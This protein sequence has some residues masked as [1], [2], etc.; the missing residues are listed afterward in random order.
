MGSGAIIA[1][2]PSIPVALPDITTIGEY[3]NPQVVSEYINAESINVC[4]S[5][6][7]SALAV[8]LMHFL[9]QSALEYASYWSSLALSSSSSLMSTVYAQ[10]QSVLQRTPSLTISDQA[11]QTED[12][13]KSRSKGER[14]KERPCRVVDDSEEEEEEITVDDDEQGWDDRPTSKGK[15][16]IKE[17][18]RPKRTQ[19]RDREN[20][21][22][23]RVRIFGGGLPI[24]DDEEDDEESIL[25]RQVREEREK[26]ELERRRRAKAQR[27]KE[28]RRKRVE[29][30]EEQQKPRNRSKRESSSHTNNK[31]KT[32]H[33]TA[34][35]EP[36]HSNRRPRQSGKAENSDDDFEIVWE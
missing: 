26:E 36:P 24:Y 34:R 19:L 7:S 29:E 23:T 9:P 11:L 15:E 17:G 6:N 28:D 25:R 16:R 2:M 31:Q 4:A 27:E 30:T 18:T 10:A 21:D 13:R 12:Q 5:S 22:E 3:I 14:S 1:N 33:A 35:D 20:T 32:K 8:S